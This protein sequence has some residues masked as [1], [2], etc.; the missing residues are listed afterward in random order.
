MEGDA[1]TRYRTLSPSPSLSLSLSL[2]SLVGKFYFKGA[3]VLCTVSF[4]SFS[5]KL[6]TFQTFSRETDHPLSV[7]P[8]VNDLSVSPS[9]Q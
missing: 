3:S 5:F 8:L 7:S 9:G 6:L 2:S 4:F 1:L